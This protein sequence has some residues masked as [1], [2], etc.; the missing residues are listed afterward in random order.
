MH[1]PVALRRRLAEHAVTA[2]YGVFVGVGAA[3]V[4]IGV[5]LIALAL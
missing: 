1:D 2:R 3:L 4:L 5:G